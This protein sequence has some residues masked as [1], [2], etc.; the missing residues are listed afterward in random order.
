MTSCLWDL[1]GGDQN[2]KQCKGCFVPTHCFEVVRHPSC[3]PRRDLSPSQARQA[4]PN[5][6]RQCAVNKEVAG[7]FFYAHLHQGEDSSLLNGKVRRGRMRCRDCGA[8]GVYNFS[9]RCAQHGYR[10]C[11]CSLAEPFLAHLRRERHGNHYSG[12]H[13]L[14]YCVQ[15]LE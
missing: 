2:I 9:W 10:H 14:L 4:G 7:S 5:P 1:Q 11:A 12:R 13:S 3:H 8:P 15:K 6:D